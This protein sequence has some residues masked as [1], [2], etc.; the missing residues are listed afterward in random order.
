MLHKMVRPDSKGRITLGHLASGVS[1]FLLTETK[2]HK[3]ILEPYSE[4]PTREK[5]LF[6]NKEALKK[7]KQGL[8]DAALGHIVKKGSFAQFVENEDDD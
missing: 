3:I 8:Q 5:W 4:I 6:D 1:G 2:D 7:V